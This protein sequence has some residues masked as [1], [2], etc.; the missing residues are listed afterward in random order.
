[1]KF[2]VELLATGGAQSARNG[3]KRD[4]AQDLV[5]CGEAHLHLIKAIFVHQAHAPQ[6]R[7]LSYGVGAFAGTDHGANSFIDYQQLGHCRA[8]FEPG[9]IADSTCSGN[10][11]ILPRGGQAGFGKA[12]GKVRSH[13]LNGMTSA[14]F[15]N[16]ALSEHAYHRR[17]NQEGMAET[18]SFVCRVDRTSWPVWATFRAIS[19]V[20]WSRISP[21]MITL[22]SC[23]NIERRTL[24]KVRPA[25]VLT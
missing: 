6:A 17:G 22:G 16:Q 2:G 5:V 12:R 13:R 10:T 23:L 24:A 4:D 1:M 7:Q 15:A 19:A 25:L 14:E 18:L 21:T 20:S 11:N 8:P 3:F 9:A